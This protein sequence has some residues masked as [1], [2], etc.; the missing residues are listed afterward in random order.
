MNMNGNGSRRPPTNGHAPPLKAAP[1]SSPASAVAHTVQQLAAILEKSDVSI[2]PLRFRVA[3][4][5]VV[6]VLVV[7]DPVVTKSM[8]D[9][10]A[11]PANG[12]ALRP[13]LRRIVEVCTTE[14]QS[15]RRIAGKLDRSC[16][17]YLRDQLREL[18]R[19]DLLELAPGGGYILRKG[20]PH[21]EA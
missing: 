3:V 10:E 16:S 20:V 11:A 4:G 9:L 6:V 2:L 12:Q 5:G 21:A 15:P 13:A 8:R 19:L 18:R 1:G 17:S 7:R 14:P